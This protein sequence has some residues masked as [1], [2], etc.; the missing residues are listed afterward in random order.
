MLTPLGRWA[1]ARSSFLTERPLPESAEELR[2]FSRAVRGRS[3]DLWLGRDASERRLKTADLSN[4][5]LIAF[6]THAI[7]AG[8]VGSIVEPGLILT[9]PLKPDDIDDGVLTAS[10]VAQLN[11][12]AEL[13]VLSGCNTAASD[14]RSGADGLSGLTRAFLNAGARNLVVS[15]WRV[16]SVATA[17]LMNRFSEE[18]AAGKPSSTAL[19]SAMVAQLRA[20]K[21]P[22]DSHPAFWA[23]F[24][25]V[26]RDR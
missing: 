9:P 10:E 16:G 2:Q 20:A 8:E 15:H 5:R 22:I 25:V 23:P 14:G 11:L 21:S 7:V 26:G 13:V 24:F 12:S 18:L 4:Y 1:S 3:E 17:A 6:A 19:Q